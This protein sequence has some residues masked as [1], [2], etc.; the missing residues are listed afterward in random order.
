MIPEF[1]LWL[2]CGL[3]T[4]WCLSPRQEITSGFF[5]IQMLVTLGLSVLIGLSTGQVTLATHPQF[6]SVQQHYLQ[7]AVFIGLLSFLG[8]IMWTLER[9]AAGF[10]YAFGI[11]LITT[12]MIVLIEFRSGL[13]SLSSLLNICNALTSAWLFGAVTCAMLL[14]HWYLTATGMKLSPLIRMNQLFAAAVVLRTICWIWMQLSAS[15]AWSEHGQLLTLR[16]AGLIG[17]LIMV[18]LTL[19]TLKYRNTQSATGVLYAATT[20]VFMGETAA[21]LLLQP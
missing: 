21:I 8:S 5:R 4:M 6:M 17:P 11:S 9:R 19:Q 16:W 3:S 18:W 1:A 15:I 7:V 13:D 14:G 10:R 2:I 20:L 12:S